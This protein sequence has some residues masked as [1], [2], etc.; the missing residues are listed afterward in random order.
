MDSTSVS[1][2]RRLRQSGQET[3]WQRFVALYAPLIFH[4]GRNHGLNH[5]DAADLVQEVLA[6]L[7]VKLPEFEYD[8]TQRFRGWLRT[9][10]LNRANDFHRRDAARPNSGHSAT[11]ERT[12]ATTNVDLFDEVEYRSFLVN[13]ALEL[14]RTE[15]RDETWQACWMQIAEGRK[16]A[17]VAQELGVPLNVVYLAK[18]RVLSRLREELCGLID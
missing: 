4:W 16:A 2:L 3:A 13:R 6:V 18:S 17:D 15:F 1:L 12:T 7:V 8:P 5:A 14:M 11:I 10:T 9:I